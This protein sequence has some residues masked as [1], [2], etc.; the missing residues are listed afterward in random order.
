MQLYTQ[1]FTVGRG[2]FKNGCDRLFIA[3]TT[4]TDLTTNYVD[5]QR[6]AI[7]KILREEYKANPDAFVEEPEYDWINYKSRFQGHEPIT[8]IVVDPDD[9]S[10]D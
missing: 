4:E 10:V 5:R 1:L 8:R 2:C 7:V 9:T 3:R 6:Q